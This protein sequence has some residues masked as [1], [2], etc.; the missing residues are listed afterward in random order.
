MYKESHVP[1]SSILRFAQITA[2]QTPRT[3]ATFIL[4]AVFQGVFMETTSRQSGIFLLFTHTR[5]I[6]RKELLYDAITTT[7]LVRV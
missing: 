3:Y 7:T 6:Y 1:T 5:G 2:E 4:H